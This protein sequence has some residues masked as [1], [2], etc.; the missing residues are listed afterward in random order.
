LPPLFKR[1]VAMRT[2]PR[3]DD[4][5]LAPEASAPRQ[6]DASVVRANVLTFGEV[7]GFLTRYLGLPA[8]GQD[9][10]LAYPG[11]GYAARIETETI[12]LVIFYLYTSV[13]QD[14]SLCFLFGA[15]D[16]S[17][18]C[19]GVGTRLAT[20]AISAARRA[21]ARPVFLVTLPER[22]PEPAAA[23]LSRLQFEEVERQIHFERKLHSADRDSDTTAFDVRVYG[24]GDSSLDTAIMD[25]HRRAYGNRPD[26]P[27]LTINLLA[28]RLA[29][30]CRYVLLY[31]GERLIG[32]S[33]LWPDRDDC[34]A[35]CIAVDRRYWRS[36]ASDALASAV[37]Y[38]A[39]E[40]GC[41]KISANATS[42]DRPARSV[43]VRHGLRQVKV[44]R[45]FRLRPPAG[46]DGR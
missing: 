21:V 15:V 46:A 13:I 42:G 12:G 27:D 23:F 8:S 14:E 32:Y 33:S 17:H 35:D 41:A 22:D 19:R 34:F 38:T 36:G 43:L 9:P 6:D 10:D 7:D 20:E 4:R 45:R 18:R 28:Q 5:R 40:L 11:L 29:S 39:S 25:L 37:L 31:A 1:I 44:T 30:H 2:S 24:G 3:S 26:T 16:P